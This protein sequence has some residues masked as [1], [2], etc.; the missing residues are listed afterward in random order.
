M[1]TRRNPIE[2]RGSKNDKKLSSTT[3]RSTVSTELLY[4]LFSRIDD[5]ETKLEAHF[6]KIVEEINKGNHAKDVKFNQ[7]FPRFCA[8]KAMDESHT[9]AKH[10]ES[11]FS[12]FF[13]YMDEQHPDVNNLNEL[14]PIMISGYVKWLKEVPKKGSNGSEKLADRSINGY[15]K[16][17]RHAF[18][19]I[20]KVGT[21]ELREPLLTIKRPRLKKKPYIPTEAEMARI[22]EVLKTL[23]KSGN[24]DAKYTA[25]I[26][27]TIV[28]MCGRT[29]ALSEL[30]FDMIEE[31]GDGG[32]VV[33]Y[34]GKH[35]VEQVKGIT[36]RWYKDFLKEWK[37]YVQK[38]YGNTPYFF[39]RKRNGDISHLT[40]EQLRTKFKEFIRLCD[41]PQLTVHSFRYIYATKLYMKGVPRDE[42]KDILG[43][44]KR[45][46]N[47]YIKATEERKK[48]AIFAHMPKVCALPKDREVG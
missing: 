4:A 36:N 16:R 40:D 23:R 3:D 20:D 13:E 26:G 29:K 11:V 46:L 44:D 12:R 18:E 39:P 27:A 2:K 9:T 35:G 22:P 37:E 10:Y 8:L 19:I 48:K 7:I 28:Q 34:I 32:P 17:L 25:F 5:I 24:E 43:V 47:F 1:L 41:L 45:T 38:K 31:N 21:Q 33:S 14:E 15:I 30:R 6:N 42:I